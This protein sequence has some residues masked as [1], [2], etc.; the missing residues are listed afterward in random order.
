MN[1]LW[2]QKH[3]QRKM[4]V[5]TGKL[6]IKWHRLNFQLGRFLAFVTVCLFTANRFGQVAGFRSKPK[7]IAGFM[8]ILCV[9]CISGLNLFCLKLLPVFA[10]G[11]LCSS[12]S[13]GG[14]P[15]AF[16]FVPSVPFCAESFLFGV[17]LWRSW[18]LGGFPP[19]S[20]R[21]PILSSD[22]L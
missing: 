19:S 4:K 14:A 6:K 15:S 13:I 18:R 17:W 12:V 10:F 8:K 3:S 7:R 11:C 16:Y 20:F 22:F 1:R 5:A 2:L 21:F 9:S